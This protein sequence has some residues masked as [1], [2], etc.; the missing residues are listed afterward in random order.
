MSIRKDGRCTVLDDRLKPEM[1]RT[2]GLRNFL[3]DQSNIDV[4]RDEGAGIWEDYLI[5][6][7]IYGIADDAVRQLNMIH[8]TYM[9][10]QTDCGSYFLAYRPAFRIIQTEI[11]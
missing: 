2:A 8:P 4:K 11:Q 9:T 5:L 6:A 10:S 7:C 3:E 1:E